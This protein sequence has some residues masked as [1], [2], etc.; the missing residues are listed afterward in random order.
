MPL[1][2]LPAVLVGLAPS[3]GLH[4]DPAAFGARQVGR[5]TAL[6]DNPLQANSLGG[7]QELDP[8]IEP[9]G[10]A[11]AVVSCTHDEDHEQVLALNERQLAHVP[12]VMEQ[13]IEGP[14]GDVIISS[15][16]E[17]QRVEVKQ[18]EG[19]ERGPSMMQ[20]RAGTAATALP[21]TPKRVVQSYPLLV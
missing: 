2:Q 19:V 8:V 4:L 15:G 6:A 13:E 9:I 1:E 11:Q 5:I 18:A 12:A 21:S 14:H 7:S 3:L 10:E 17:M 20:D 16:A